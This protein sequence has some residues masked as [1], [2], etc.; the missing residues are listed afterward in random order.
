MDMTGV[1][2]TVGPVD[3]CRAACVVETGCCYIEGRMEDHLEAGVGRTAALEV[4][5]SAGGK[6]L[7]AAAMRR[8][9]RWAFH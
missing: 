3:I 8:A 9:D 6:V 2:V 1:R 4:A 5:A 7:A